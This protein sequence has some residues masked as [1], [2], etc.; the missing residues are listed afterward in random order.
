VAAE[1]VRRF[2]AGRRWLLPVLVI[3]QTIDALVAGGLLLLRNWRLML[4]ELVPAM[5]LGALTWDW[6]TRATGRLPLAE[7][8]GLAAVGVALFVIAATY[9]A[10]WCNAVFAF[11]AVQTPPTNLR[12]AVQSA[13]SRC[14]VIATWALLAGL[15]HAVVAVFVTRTTV[16]AYS[17]ALGAVVLVQMY[18]L[19]A[20]PVALV[21]PKATR[22]RR[23]LRER[24]LALALTGAVS[25]VAS[26]PGFVLNRVG[27]LLFAVGAPWLGVLVLVPAVIVQAAG[28]ASARAV[29]LAARVS[30]TSGEDPPPTDPL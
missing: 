10:Y 9:A 15:A 27:L 28:A 8:Y 12:R 16:L 17:I 6:R 13:T 20:L 11:T 3:G 25:G 22:E 18:G 21:T 24:I 7:V 30:G 14:R 19:V 5:W 1:N 26:T 29:Q 2:V 23:T 4:V